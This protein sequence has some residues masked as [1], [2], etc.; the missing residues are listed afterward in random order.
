M[1]VMLR[2]DPF[3]NG[4]GSSSDLDGDCSGQIRCCV[5]SRDNR[6]CSGSDLDGSRGGGGE[7]PCPRPWPLLGI[8]PQLSPWEKQALDDQ[9]L[10]VASRPRLTPHELRAR[11]RRASE[12]RLAGLTF[13]QV[14]DQL[15]YAG[16]S[17]PFKA[18]GA[19]T[20]AGDDAAVALLQRSLAE[21]AAL[22]AALWPR[23]VSGHMPSVD[24]V[25]AIMARRSRLLGLDAPRAP[26]ARVERF[27]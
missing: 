17:G 5:C 6:T 11:Q 16:P 8:V 2:S 27:R 19:A 7:P 23:A 15:G 9:E 1:T 22:D 3:R 18:V 10:S 14:A 26:A 21:L 25:L 20:R 12:L 13:Q 4:T 24:R